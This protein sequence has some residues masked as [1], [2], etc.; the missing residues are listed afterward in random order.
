MVHFR[1]P[2]PGSEFPV[3]AQPEFELV[4]RLHAAVVREEDVWQ[5]R[6]P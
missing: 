2:F 3:S 4:A 1:F 5:K 6:T